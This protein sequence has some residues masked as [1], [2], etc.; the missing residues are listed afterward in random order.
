MCTT[1]YFIIP[2]YVLTFT[3]AMVVIIHNNTSYFSY[4]H[5][6]GILLVVNTILAL[7]ILKNDNDDEEE[8]TDDDDYVKLI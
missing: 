2:I 5:V 7:Y 1:C 4:R 3:L 6:M 8:E